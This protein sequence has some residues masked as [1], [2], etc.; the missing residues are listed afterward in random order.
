MDCVPNGWTTVQVSN[1]T[2]C[3]PLCDL[4]IETN[5]L[6]NL[7]IKKWLKSIGGELILI[8]I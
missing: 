5:F 7:P 4:H 3:W 8:A 6:F 2:L 1:I